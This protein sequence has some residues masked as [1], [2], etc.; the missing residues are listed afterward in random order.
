MVKRLA[1]LFK[2]QASSDNNRRDSKAA[3]K[4]E[5]PKP[6]VM[7]VCMDG[8]CLSCKLYVCK[9]ARP[10]GFLNKETVF[11][12]MFYVIIYCENPY[13]SLLIVFNRWCWRPVV[14]Q[15]KSGLRNTGFL[16]QQISKRLFLPVGICVW[17]KA[18]S[19]C[20]DTCCRR[21]SGCVIRNQRQSL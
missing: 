3:G 12:W 18:I 13:E 7:C 2:Q 5:A 20:R 11:W 21:Q 4:K 16:Y 17:R 6:D 1:N 10:G 15:M 8:R 9:S 14:F 19:Q